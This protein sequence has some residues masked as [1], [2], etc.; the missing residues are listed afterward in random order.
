MQNRYRTDLASEACEQLEEERSSLEG[1]AVR[2][3]DGTIALKTGK[4]DFLRNK[5]KIAR[6]PIIRG[7]IF[8]LFLRLSVF[9]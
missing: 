5:Y 2:R 8:S 7:I 3:E 4:A 9:F 1:L 6:V